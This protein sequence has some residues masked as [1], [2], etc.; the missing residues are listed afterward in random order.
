MNNIC[1]YLHINLTKQEVFYVGIGNLLRP[2]K[3]KDRSK[4][5]RKITN[6]YPYQIIILHENLSWEEASELEIKYIKQIGRRDLKLGPLVNLTNGGG[7]GVRGYKHTRK[8]RK[9][10]SGKL[11]GR[12]CSPEH[13]KNIGIGS[14]RPCTAAAK[15]KL[16]RK[17]KKQWSDPELL[18]KFKKRTGASNPNYG[19][20]AGSVCILD[21][22]DNVIRNL[23]CLP[24]AAKALGIKQQRLRKSIKAG[25]SINNIFYQFKKDI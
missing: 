4:F 16:R 9:L 24:D 18:N 25:I 14:Q 8:T 10:I 12:T 21:V 15:K 17:A 7:Y 23:G 6:K 2:Y 19:G 20:S 5:W 1:V 11:L 22:N 13:I 3:V